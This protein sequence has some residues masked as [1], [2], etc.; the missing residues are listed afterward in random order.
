MLERS[1][2]LGLDS[3]SRFS[4]FEEPSDRDDALGWLESESS[5]ATRRNSRWVDPVLPKDM[6]GWR[7]RRPAT[8]DRGE[9]SASTW[10]TELSRLRPVAWCRTVPLRTVLGAG[11]DI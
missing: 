10:K 4:A 1:R 8:E 3:G 9:P 7:G 6:S 5:D 11:E 2:V